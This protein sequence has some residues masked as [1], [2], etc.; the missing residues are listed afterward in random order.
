MATACFNP[1]TPLLHTNRKEQE[2]RLSAA[3]STFEVSLK[4]LMEERA[5]LRAALAGVQSH[6]EG[7][8][9]DTPGRGMSR[10]RAPGP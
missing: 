6:L 9:V 7:L 2:A 4:T 8:P 1:P 5:Q 3:W 10:P